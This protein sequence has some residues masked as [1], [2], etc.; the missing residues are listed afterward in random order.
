MDNT[1]INGYIVTLKIKIFQY[2]LNKQM[3]F[4]VQN[5]YFYFL[6]LVS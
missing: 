5:P 1:F 3:S 4:T 6:F 2:R